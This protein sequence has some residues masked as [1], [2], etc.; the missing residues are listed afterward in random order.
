MFSFPDQ[1]RLQENPDGTPGDGSFIFAEFAFD[2]KSDMQL[3]QARGL[4][5]NR[6]DL[7]NSD[8]PTVVP[9]QK[10]P[11]V[12]SLFSYWVKIPRWDTLGERTCYG[13]L[14]RDISWRNPLKEI[15]GILPAIFMKDFPTWEYHGGY[16]HR[17]G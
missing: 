4:A 2:A 10:N 17:I 13:D 3:Q 8:T 15:S 12:V 16:N 1:T 9:P 6:C 5:K 11:T 14:K 7:T